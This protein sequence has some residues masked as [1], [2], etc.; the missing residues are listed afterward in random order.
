MSIY[1]LFLSI[2]KINIEK[3]LNFNIIFYTLIYNLLL[4]NDTKW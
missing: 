2:L 4:G 3:K 1:F